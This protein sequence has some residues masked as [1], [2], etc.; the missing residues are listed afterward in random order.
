MG[1]HVTIKVAAERL[2]VSADTVRRRLRAGELQGEKRSDPQGPTWYVEL[3]DDVQAVPPIGA[4][5]IPPA[6]GIELVRLQAQLEGAQALIDE[7]RDERDAWRDQA[8]R[9][10]QAAEQLRV[11]VQ[12]AQVLAGSA[13]LPAGSSSTQQ[14][15]IEPTPSP[16]QGTPMGKPRRG[17]RFW[18]Q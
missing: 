17:L 18:K 1:E 9:H 13:A 5:V 12:Q 10:E 7:L 8:S 2:G 6:D 4:E 11:L 15:N 3:P 16:A 14:A